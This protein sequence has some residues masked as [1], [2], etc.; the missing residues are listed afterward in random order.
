[1]ELRS[2]L[3]NSSSIED[4]GVVVEQRSWL[5]E[6]AGQSDGRRKEWVRTDSGDGT[7]A[8]RCSGS[9]LPQLEKQPWHH[10]A[11]GF[12]AAPKGQLPHTY[13]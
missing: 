10:S 5:D 1:M 7:Q 9:P 2:D 12:D 11:A 13:A 8:P 6:L 4:R 3:K